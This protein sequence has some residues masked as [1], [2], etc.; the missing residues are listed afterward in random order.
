MQFEAELFL[1]RYRD[2]LESEKLPVRHEAPMPK[3]DDMSE[4]SEFRTMWPVISAT[5]MDVVEVSVRLSI[6][7]GRLRDFVRLLN[8]IHLPGLFRTGIADG[9]SGPQLRV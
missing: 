4:L 8:F 7:G 5:S 3:P 6:L 1:G 9:L 2:L